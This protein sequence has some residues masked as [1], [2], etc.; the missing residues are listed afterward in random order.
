MQADTS[1]HTPGRNFRIEDGLYR[2]ALKKARSQH[3][4]LASVV[5]ELLRNYVDETPV[6]DDVNQR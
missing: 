1:A 6:G 3:R 2:A 4:T 5:R